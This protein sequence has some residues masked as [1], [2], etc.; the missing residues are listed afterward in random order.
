LPFLLK[1]YIINLGDKMIENAKKILNHAKENK[2]AIAQLNINNL[3]WTKYILEE[4]QKNNSPVILGVSEGAIKYM[5]GYNVVV[6]MIKAL[7]LDL[8]ITIPT[9][10]HLDHATSYESCK[11]AIDAGFTS[12][13]IDTS[14]YSLEE[15]IRIT[16]QVVA[17]AQERNVSV[18]AEV[19]HIGGTEDD[20]IADIAYAKVDDCVK[21]ANEAKITMLAP[22]LGSVHGLYKGEPKLDFARMKEIKEKTNLP[23]VLHGGSG[24]YDDMILKA[25][26]FGTA[27]IN[28]NTELQIAWHE[29]VKNFIASNNDEYDPRKVI[30]SGET[31]LKQVVFEKIKLFGSINRC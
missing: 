19:G 21:L 8:N 17:Y 28:V 14:K 2:Y 23:L 31:A 13:M 5:G 25:I 12:V 22:A 10:I 15:N 7:V 9:V 16:N 20:I 3:E 18:E 29:A 27:K 30:K 4:C 11:K 26:E 1:K 6:Q 24:I